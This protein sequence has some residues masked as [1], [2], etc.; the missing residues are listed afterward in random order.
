M[1]KKIIVSGVGCSLVDRLF[2]NISFSSNEFS[3]Y[4][5]KESGDGGLVPGQLVFVEEFEKFADENHQTI[6]KAITN[7]RSH[8]KINIGGPSIVSI[9]HAAQLSFDN[10]SE[11]RFYGGRGDDAQ[12]EFIMKLLEGT[13]VNAD[14]YIVTEGET[15]STL[16]LS[17][18]T[19]DNNAGERI[20]I[21]SIGSAWNYTPNQLDD[22]FFS[23]DIVVFGGTALVPQIHD[24]LTE[25]LEKAK[26]EGCITIVNT[27]YDFRNEKANPD[28]K[29]PLGKSDES[30]RNIDLLITD[31]EEAL[32]LSGMSNIDSSIDFFLNKGIG[33]LIITSGTDNVRLFAQG[34]LFGKIEYA[35]MPISKAVSEDLKNGKGN[36]GDTTGCGDNF[37]GGVI[38]SIVK[39]IQEPNTGIDLKEATTYGIVS[40]GTTTFYMGGMY[41]EK[42]KG[43]KKK[44]IESYYKLYKDQN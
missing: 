18:P 29:W 28:K 39:Q 1:S 43:E 16:V 31:L 9:I 30:Y 25:L 2:N 38:T 12:G 19:Y 41:E 7:N 8:D 4:L 6:L 17:D 32:R 20:F 3:S 21:N 11:F 24:N 26:S 35:E 22:S 23:S 5:S 37:V 15:P 42:E 33:A 27:V 14:N 36:N 40:G 44:M 13:S 10:N 34:D